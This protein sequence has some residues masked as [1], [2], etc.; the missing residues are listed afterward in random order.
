M[1]SKQAHLQEQENQ[2]PAKLNEQPL[3][4]DVVR[5]GKQLNV[6][7]LQQKQFLK[8]KSIRIIITNSEGLK[9]IVDSFSH[10]ESSIVSPKSVSQ[11]EFI[12]HYDWKVYCTSSSMLDTA[13][14]LYELP[15]KKGIEV[16]PLTSLTGKLRRKIFERDTCLA[17]IIYTVDNDEVSD[18][19]TVFHNKIA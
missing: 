6:K 18:K 12:E 10:I 17:I 5:R 7:E 16:H 13:E 19:V 9:Q 1:K 15:R 2:T 14:K 4:E 3:I 11:D 8:A